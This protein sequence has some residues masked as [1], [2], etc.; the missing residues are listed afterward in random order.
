MSLISHF[1]VFGIT[2]RRQSEGWRASQS[3]SSAVGL[4]WS[5][6]QTQ[7]DYLF[8]GRALQ[9]VWLEAT[10]ADVGLC[11]VVTLC[12]LLS[13]WRAGRPLTALQAAALPQID[14]RF[15]ALFELPESRGDIVL[16][17]L[18]PAADAL[19]ASRATYR[20]DRSS[21]AEDGGAFHAFVPRRDESP[22]LPA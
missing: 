6:T 1:S 7:L 12:Y 15:R 3:S 19:N 14:R 16:F 10:R 8:G 2:T 17:R 4:I 9:R 11:P 20:R 5:D 18:L 13:A 22:A 21:V